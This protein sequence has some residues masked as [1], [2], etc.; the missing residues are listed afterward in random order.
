[1][2]T[3]GR[4]VKWLISGPPLLFLLVFF[5]VP[6]LIMI[7]TSFRLPGEFGGLA[8]IHILPEKMN[9][10]SGLT[11]ETYQF[12]FSDLIYIEIFLKSFVV[13]TFTTLI[14][15]CPQPEEI[16]QSDDHVRCASVCQ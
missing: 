2:R 16:S 1:M 10:N 7:L 5:V 4:L 9:G 14:T 6:S 13:A 3:S 15:D 8:P 11:I 12:F